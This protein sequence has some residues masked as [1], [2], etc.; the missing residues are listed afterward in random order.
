MCI[1][2][3]NIEF[4]KDDSWKSDSKWEPALI[5]VPMQF[6]ILDSKKYPLSTIIT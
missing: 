5:I 1:M 6:R 3:K 2:I 4:Y